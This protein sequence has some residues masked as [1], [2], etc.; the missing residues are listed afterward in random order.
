[1]LAFLGVGVGCLC[2]LE[3]SDV[4]PDVESVVLYSQYVL[5]DVVPDFYALYLFYVSILGSS[6]Q[7]FCQ[8]YVG[9]P[10]FFHLHYSGMV[11]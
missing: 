9:P 3:L 1:M 4:S 2:D 7:H 11:A 5:R 6:S 10:V 8:C